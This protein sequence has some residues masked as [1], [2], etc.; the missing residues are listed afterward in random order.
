M[1]GYWC[2][3]AEHCKPVLSPVVANCW[4]D[5]TRTFQSISSRSFTKANENGPGDID[6]SLGYRRRGR[7]WNRIKP[8]PRN[9]TDKCFEHNP[10]IGP[11]RDLHT[12]WH[13]SYFSSTKRSSYKN[14]F[15]RILSKVAEKEER[16]FLQNHLKVPHKFLFFLKIPNFLKIHWFPKNPK[17]I[18]LFVPRLRLRSKWLHCLKT[19]LHEIL[20]VSLFERAFKMMKNGV[21]FTVIALL[22]AV[23]FKILIYA[24]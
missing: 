18:Q 2:K 7:V 12:R 20:F 1:P 4:L 22:V 11:L 21:Y 19:L 16:L 15:R 10:K 8:I 3:I 17:K 6:V 14:W 9:T 13:S 23:L 5:G 24:N